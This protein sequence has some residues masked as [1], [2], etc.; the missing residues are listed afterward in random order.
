MRTQPKRSNFEN[1]TYD[2]LMECM[3]GQPNVAF[4]GINE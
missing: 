3:S 1:S 2:F 4:L